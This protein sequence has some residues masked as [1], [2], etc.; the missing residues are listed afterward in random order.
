MHGIKVVYTPGCKAL[1]DGGSDDDTV[2]EAR[3]SGA[4]VLF[5]PR[6]RANQLN[7]GARAAQ[8][9][10]CRL[11]LQPTLKAPGTK[12]LKLKY[13]KL[14][15]SF[16]FNFQLAPLHTG[17]HPGVPP[18]GRAVQVEPMKRVLKAPGTK[19]LK[20]QYDALFSSFAFKFNL[21]RY[22]ADSTLPPSYDA[23][24]HR[25]F[26]AQPSATE[27]RRRLTL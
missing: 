14:L 10:R 22:N 16:T 24:L 12:R 4:T 21:R 8:V 6:G 20:A 5:S 1:R 27:R 26:T 18:R 23:Q 13:E 7:A 17:R 9:G 19:H 2:A 3:D 25:L 15:S 11:S